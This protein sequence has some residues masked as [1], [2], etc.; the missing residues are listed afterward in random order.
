MAAD[1]L[2][3]TVTGP[4]GD[5]QT[6]DMGAYL[7]GLC[8]EFRGVQAAQGGRVEITVEAADVD[9]QRLVLADAARGS[10]HRGSGAGPRA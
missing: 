3:V 1:G 4:T 6:V 9:Q 5:L 2:T 7:T 8:D 10:R